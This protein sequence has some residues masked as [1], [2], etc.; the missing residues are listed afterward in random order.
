[1]QS[2]QYVMNQPDGR[3][4]FQN[5]EYDTMVI[6]A[7]KDNTIITVNPS[8]AKRKELANPKPVSKAQATNGNPVIAAAHATIKREL[9][10]VR[11]SFT[12]EYRRLTE[13]IAVIGLEI[14]QLTLNMAR[15]RSPIT[16]DLIQR[17]IDELHAEAGRKDGDKADKVAEY[18]AVKA[19]AQAYIGETV[20]T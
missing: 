7:A 18:R 12:K 17:K 1:M 4:I 13:E 3:R 11:R 15:A 20:T 14:A 9:A 19:E 10:K 8:A 5:D 6:L 16:Q 2:A